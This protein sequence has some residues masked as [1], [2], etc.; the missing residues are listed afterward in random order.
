MRRLHSPARPSFYRPCLRASSYALAL[1]IINLLSPGATPS[2][3]QQGPA[4]VAT[5]TPRGVGESGAA[6]EEGGEAGLLEPGKPVEREMRG[7]ETH[8]YRVALAQGQYLR[9]LINQRG[10]DVVV[11]LAGPG[12]ERLVE[13]N[14]DNGTYGVEPISLIAQAAGPHTLEVKA[15]EQ[16]APAGRYDVKL[17]QLR[18]ATPE[19]KNR[20]AAER[21]FLEGDALRAQNKPA[22][23][24]QA[25]VKYQEALAL[26][27]GASDPLIEAQALHGLG[28]LHTVFGN[29]PQA[30][31]YYL[32]ALP[33]RRAAGDR[34]GEATTLNSIGATYISLKELQ[35]ALAAFKQALPVRR[36]VGDRRGE[37]VTLNNIGVIY[38]DLGEYE[39]AIEYYLQSL[40]LRRELGDQEGEVQVLYNLGNVHKRAG[41]VKATLDYYRQALDAA[42]AIEQRRGNFPTPELVGDLHSLLGEHRK[43]LDYF[44]QALTLARA[45]KRMLSE[46]LLVRKMAHLYHQLGE[47]DKAT[48][49]YRQAL[50]LIR[51]VNGDPNDAQ[52]LYGLARIESERG[53]LSAALKYVEAAL[54]AV[55][56][57]RSKIEM[58]DL[59]AS[60]FATNQ[61]L[62]ALNIDLLMRMHKQDPAKGYDAAAL[63]VS[64]RARA[65]TLLELLIEANA[66]IREGADPA[67][68]ERE[69]ALQEK[70][71]AR[72]E[73]LRRLPGGRTADEQR[74]ALKNELEALKT[75]YQEVQAEIRKSSPRYAA[76]AHPEPL[77]IPDI[78]RKVLDPDTLLL[79]YAF[80]VERSYLWAVT[81]DG[82]SSYELP[83][84][85]EV[86]A[87]ARQVYGLLTAR[88]RR[89]R[90]ETPAERRARVARA[91]Q[92]FPEAAAALSRM[93]LGPVAT[94]LGKKRL[95]IVGEGALQFIPF[96]ALPAPQAAQGRGRSAGG[97]RQ[98]PPADYTPL[99]VDHE[100]VNLPSA[101]SLAVLRQAVAGRKPAPKA[102][103]VIADPVFEETDERLTSALRKGKGS[104][105]QLAQARMIVAA[106]DTDVVRAAA[107]AGAEGA[108]A[109]R[110]PRLPFTRRE[111][112]AITALVPPAE[113]KRLFDFAANRA[114]A[115]DPDL[116]RYRY[117]HFATHGILNTKHPE[118]SGVVLS[119]FDERGREQDGFLRAHE[120]FN[121]KL[122]AELVVLSGCRT[123]L[124]KQIRGE[125]LLGL[126]RGFMYAGAARVVVSLWDVNDEATAELMARFYGAMLGRE[127]QRP[128]AALRAAQVA[129]WRERRWRPP[130][131]WAAFIM[132]GEPG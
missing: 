43:A 59:R 45:G 73:Q 67:L 21:V 42:R 80:G 2:D 74:A 13:S 11:S 19:D 49:C 64:E 96:G 17:E 29:K 33:L 110:I 95:L 78:R 5:S 7:G 126:T 68:L 121:L 66:H 114:A 120:I 46:A 56:S 12:G 132:Q 97:G 31:A 109:Q 87:K 94:Q 100:V 130:Y 108:A 34:R 37:A 51:N 6:K 76:L 84:R 122:P 58:E 107:D 60:F 26:L 128:A 90:F 50:A 89:E 39:R 41:D 55:E 127:Q 23:M 83:S 92:E 86:E 24:Q 81:T 28:R 53:N 112:E 52:S 4:P 85:G 69:R 35:K 111:A 40:P 20:V 98:S 125:G 38:S 118:L 54:P 62:Y 131:Y 82:M 105:E 71:N 88:N 77:G 27:K 65:R 106:E 10:I 101:S 48:E 63:Q 57:I 8:A 9:V 102:V 103:A 61:T 99:V 22:P 18:A 117:I 47:L 124:G 70:L 113:R 36:E 75:A 79:E 30:L 129:M 104:G 116:G 115:T 14:S 44:N 25:M 123:G 93:L 1:V 119:L 16:K 3:A 72:A 32:Q 15:L 91:D